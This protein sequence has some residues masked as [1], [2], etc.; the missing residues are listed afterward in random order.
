MPS[1]S[2][3]NREQQTELRSAARAQRARAVFPLFPEL[4]GRTWL[5]FLREELHDEPSLSLHTF[6]RD[7]ITVS[8]D[9]RSKRGHI[10]V[11]LSREKLEVYG[12]LWDRGVSAGRVASFSLADTA[13]FLERLWLATLHLR[14]FKRRCH[15]FA[16]PKQD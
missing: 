14:L 15:F 2:A 4:K 11:H 6:R 13:H 10:T 1:E 5:E 12:D 7:P 9:V 3:Q 16:H 8:V